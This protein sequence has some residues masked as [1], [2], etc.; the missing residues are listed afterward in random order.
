[1]DKSSFTNGA[2]AAGFFKS[3]FNHWNWTISLFY[4][5]PGYDM[6][7]HVR[8][9]GKYISEKIHTYRLCAFDF[10]KVKR[11]RDDGMLRTLHTDKLLKT[12]P[13]LQ[14]QIDALLEF[15]VNPIRKENA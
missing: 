5:F 11:G 6:S 14:S 12:M 1:V 4:Q 7:T 10:C 15:Q 3:I 8:R 13:I 9:Y 2:I